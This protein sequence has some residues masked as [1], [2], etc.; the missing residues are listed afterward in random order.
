MPVGGRAAF[1]GD[2]GRA[3]VPG[4]ALVEMSIF[5]GLDAG[6]GESLS[7][8]LVECDERLGTGIGPGRGPNGA[9]AGIGSLGGMGKPGGNAWL[10]GMNC[11]GVGKAGLKLGGM[12]LGGASGF[13]MDEIDMGFDARPL[14]SDKGSEDFACERRD[15]V[16]SGSAFRSL[17]CAVTFDGCVSSLTSS[18]GSCYEIR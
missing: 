9:A 15:A 11:P 12:K 10:G 14:S 3:G 1:G 8:P 18:C 4:S 6:S 13:M 2:G 16:A 5:E 17:S 7:D